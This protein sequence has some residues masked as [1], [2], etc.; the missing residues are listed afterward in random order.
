MIIN[1]TIDVVELGCCR[2]YYY[3]LVDTLSH[4]LRKALKKHPSNQ[5]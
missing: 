4:N 2:F 1:E 5:G 3:Q